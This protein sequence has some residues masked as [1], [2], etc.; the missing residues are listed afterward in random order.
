MSFALPRRK[1]M[2]AVAALAIAMLVGNFCCPTAFGQ[3]LA[4]LTTF[5]SN[6]WLAPGAIPQLTQDNN[7]RGLGVSPTTGNLILPSRSSSALGN[8]VW[9]ISGSTGVVSGSFTPPVSGTSNAY[10]G[11]TFVINGAGVGADG[12]VYV[13]NLS[14]SAASAFK[15]YKWASDSDFVTPAS[16][17][18]SGTFTGGAPRYGD[19]FAVYGSGTAAKFAAAGSNTA[20]SNVNSYFAVGT[21]SGTSTQ[22]ATAYLQVV[23]SQTTTAGNNGYRLGLSFIN[24]SSLLG[25]QGGNKLYSTTFSPSVSNIETT[26][27]TN[28]TASNRPIA[29]LS[30]N[31]TPYVATIDTNSSTV[32]LFDLTNPALPLLTGTG[33]TTVGTLA[34]NLNGTGGIGWGP[35]LGNDQYTLYAMSSNQG[36]QAFVVTVPEPSTYAV[37]GGAFAVIGLVASRKRRSA[38]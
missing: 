32:S 27:T 14:S 26:G 11:G 23:N 1:E 4:P 37:M 24:D 9:S 31:G 34:S 25:T 10:S 29:Y 21:L 17:A 7:Q 33:N 22:S 16:V 12:A 15:V 5:G 3:T 36:I 18:F 8:N 35:Y 38:R 20:S 13:G 6:G 2:I 30:H 19:A 28:W